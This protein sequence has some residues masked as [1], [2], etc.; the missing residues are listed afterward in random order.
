MFK[1]S[2]LNEIDSLIKD[3]SDNSLKPC[4]EEENGNE[5]YNVDS[6]QDITL[7]N[8]DDK[9]EQIEED[10]PEDF[11]NNSNL[12]E[13][14]KDVQQNKRKIE[15]SFFMLDEEDNNEPINKKNKLGLIDTEQ[16]D[17]YI[18]YQID[19]LML[20]KKDVICCDGQNWLTNTT[21]YAYMKTYE[22]NYNI[23]V[24]DYF[25]TN[26]FLIKTNEPI[27]NIIPKVN[28][29]LLIFFICIN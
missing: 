13:D 25:Q 22:K 4:L 19:N 8:E 18:Y 28:L 21:I 12:N 24:L 20:N 29:Y 23:L 2:N 6:S 5:E 14:V 9:L 7:G 17:G 1:V 27:G 10:L 3:F 15:Q 26:K 16:A 11:F